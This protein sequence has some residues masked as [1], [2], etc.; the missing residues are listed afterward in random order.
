MPPTV[1]PPSVTPTPPASPSSTTSTPT[2]LD[3]L[4]DTAKKAATQARDMVGKLTHD[5]R[6]RI[7]AAL[8]KAGAAVERSTG[9]KY[10]KQIESVKKQLRHGVDMVAGQA[11]QAG[12]GP[13]SA[14]PGGTT[15]PTAPAAPGATPGSPTSPAS[16][17]TPPAKPKEGWHRGPNG[18]WVR[19]ES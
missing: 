8:D 5:N 17:P 1:T 14:T 15:S 7:D 3:G 13:G 9:G 10:G 19:S 18:E 6:H 4:L 16:A 11:P 2:S 12:S